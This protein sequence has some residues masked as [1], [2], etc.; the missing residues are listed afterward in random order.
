M[1][2]HKYIFFLFFCAQGG[3][4]PPTHKVAYWGYWVFLVFFGV[5]GCPRGFCSP[6][7]MV[8]GVSSVFWASVL[9]GVCT[10]IGGDEIW[11]F[12]MILWCFGFC[13]VCMSFYFFGVL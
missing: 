13:G 10:Y 12:V 6:W 4:P 11:C 8:I 5:F 7:Y 3:Y 1:C 2:A 9:Y